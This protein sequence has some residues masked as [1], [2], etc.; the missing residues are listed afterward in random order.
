MPYTPPTSDDIHHTVWLKPE[1]EAKGTLGFFCRLLTEEALEEGTRSD[2]LKSA[3]QAMRVIVGNLHRAHLRDPNLFV[4]VPHDN[5]MLPKGEFNPIGLG[6][7]GFRRAL[8]ILENADPPYVEKRGGGYNHEDGYGLATRLRAAERLMIAAD[9][10]LAKLGPT[11]RDPPVTRNTS[12]SQKGNPYSI[13]SNPH[14]IFHQ[15]IYAVHDLPTIR[16]KAPKPG[17][18]KPAPLIPFEPTEE[19]SRMAANLKRI[20]DFL[21]K[22]CWI[23]LFVPDTDLPDLRKTPDEIDD[24][25][26]EEE[27]NPDPDILF[28]RKLYRVFNNRTFDDG[29]RFYGAWWQMIPSASRRY[30]TINWYTTAELDYSALQLNMLYALEGKSPPE[31]SYELDGFPPDKR[32][33]LKKTFFKLINAKK[34]MREPSKGSLPDGWS[35]DAILTG[36]MSLHEPVAKYFRSGIGIKLQRIDSDIAEK[37]MLTLLED[38]I[39]ALP[40]HDSFIVQDGAQRYLRDVMVSAYKERMGQ[41]IEV[42]ADTTWLEENL[43]AE[44]YLLDELGV[45]FIDDFQS[46]VEELDEYRLYRQRRHDFLDYKSEKWGHEHSFFH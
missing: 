17:R 6:S 29:G 23:D 8:D 43:P 1:L 3:V 33:L 15:W 4:I 26:N 5:A 36:L 27:E 40:V 10:W 11:F 2:A 38:G 16:L 24:A 34:Q 39:V 37:V 9:P 13:F 44:A 12:D 42:T 21:E 46:D 7:R 20:N 45:R 18:G 28:R 25:F 30:I 32:K 14:S 22:E 41:E 35:W 19:T 31:R